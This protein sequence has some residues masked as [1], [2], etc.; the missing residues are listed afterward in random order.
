MNRR[1]FLKITALLAGTVAM[2]SCSV[3]EDGDE[4]II[5]VG[6]G[7]AGLSAAQTL[8]KWGYKVVV[9]EARSRVGGRIWTSRKWEDAPLDLGASWIHGV[10]GNPIAK[11]AK[12]NRIKIVET[13]YDNQ[14]IYKE[15]GS[16]LTNEEYE[17]LE[18]YESTITEYIAEAIAERDDDVPLKSI[19]DAVLDNVS[20]S[21]DEK[22]IILYL[23]NTIV[24]HEYAAD[25]SELSLFTFDEGDEYSGEDVIFPG[26]YDQIIEILAKGLD[27]RLNETVQRVA[28]EEAG[29][30]IQTNK[31]IYKGDRAVITLP[32]GVLKSGQ[33]DFSP[34]LPSEKQ[35]AIRRLGMGLLDKLY[36]R[37]PS[38]FWEKDAALL[39]YLGE[40]KGEWA[41]WLNI[42]H[43]TNKPILLGFNAATFARKVDKWSDQQI[44]DSAMTML[45]NIFGA[46]IPDPLDWQITRWADDPF[47]WGSYSYLAP[48]TNSKTLKELARSVDGKLFFAGEATSSDYQSTVHGA[49]LS[50]IRAAEEIWVI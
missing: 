35:D 49:Y 4:K 39:G 26:G 21:A 31:G 16:E 15:D 1:D 3:F 14:W 20:V 48:G 24:E 23:L 5:V 34:S 18:E 27:I 28:Y 44:V 11:L 7:I 9:L 13:D 43:Y 40:N 12:E 2:N 19:V 47:S 42:A 45:R 8:Q 6:A 10:S 30:S 50:G 29:V 33:V 36:L 25:I 38:I 46:N 32:L 37:F 22:Q 17:S 41:E